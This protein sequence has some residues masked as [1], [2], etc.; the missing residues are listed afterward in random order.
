LIYQIRGDEIL[1]VAVA[2]LRRD[3]TYWR[4]RIGDE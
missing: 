1:I 4:N 2:H 3:A